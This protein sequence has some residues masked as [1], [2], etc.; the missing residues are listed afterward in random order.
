[1]T[2]DLRVVFDT[3]VLI[4]QMIL[5]RSKPSLAVRIVVRR[6]RLLT[7]EEQLRELFEVAMRPKFD[8][9]VAPN[10]RFQELR[11]LAAFAQRVQIVRRVHICRDPKDDMLLEIAASGRASHLVTGDADLLDLKSLEGVPILTPA[12]FLLSTKA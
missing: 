11:R 9:Y 2:T 7:S 8:S 1:M 5:P 12:A 3:N 4:S 10:V 6:G